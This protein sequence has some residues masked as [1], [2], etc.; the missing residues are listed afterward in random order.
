MATYMQ[1]I[2]KDMKVKIEA[3][4][5]EKLALLRTLLLATSLLTRLYFCLIKKTIDPE[6]FHQVKI[7][8]LVFKNTY[9]LGSASLRGR[10]LLELSTMLQS[11][12]RIVL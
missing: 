9:V 11:L 7:R 4:I 1:H 3:R 5:K 10:L 2:A 6:Q 8:A 12:A